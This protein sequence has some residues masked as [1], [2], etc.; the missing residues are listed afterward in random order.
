MHGLTTGKLHVLG[1][2]IVHGCQLRCIG[3]PNSGRQPKVRFMTPEVFGACLG[4]VD[5]PRVKVLRLF[6]YGEPMLHP[7]PAS[8]LR[9]VPRQRFQVRSVELSTNAQTDRFDRLAEML[10][11]G[12]LDTLVVS[13][14]GDGT[15]A[16]YERLRPPGR[17]ERLI[18]FMARARE[19]RDARSPKTRLM[20]RTI[21]PSDEG[22]RRWLDLLTPLGFEPEFRGWS[23]LPGSI[24]NPSGRTAT[25]A[26]GPCIFMQRKTLYVDYDGTVVACCRHP[27]AGV[28]GNL[29]ETR[30]SKLYRG[31]ARRQF[32]HDLKTRRGGMPICGQCEVR[33]HRH[34]IERL[35]EIPLRWLSGQKGR[36]QDGEFEE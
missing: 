31:P 18:E 35:V 28:F 12:V 7:D 33:P 2:D 3:C 6:N 17:W 21:C 16:D 19:L 36:E 10:S 20:T 11:T 32:L 26:N 29:T 23:N 24:E 5:V 14:D 15:P 34:K 1:I 22:R 4:N 13:C 9:L 25:A 30:F 8:L 27:Q